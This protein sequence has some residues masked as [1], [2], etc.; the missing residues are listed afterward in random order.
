MKLKIVEKVVISETCTSLWNIFILRWLNKSFLP[1]WNLKIATVRR[2]RRERKKNSF[3][4]RLDSKASDPF[5]FRNTGIWDFVVRCWSV[6]RLPISIVIRDLFNPD[7]NKFNRGQSE[8]WNLDL[9]YPF[10]LFLSAVIFSFLM[11]SR[12]SS[13][14]IIEFSS[15]TPLFSFKILKII[16]FQLLSQTFMFQ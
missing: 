12:Q 16:I 14:F 7:S 4:V 3:K 15:F 11:T 13:I 5:H 6:I 2:R 8:R 9:V 1:I 10:A